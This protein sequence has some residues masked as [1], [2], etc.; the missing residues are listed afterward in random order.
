MTTWRT[1]DHTEISFN[2]YGS[3]TQP[4]TLLLLP[5]LLGSQTSQW[6][7]FI[8]PLSA[9]FRVVTMDLRGHGRSQNNADVLDPQRMILDISEL[10]DF[11]KVNTVH[12]AGYDMGGY[13]GMMLALNQPRR[14]ATLLMHATKFYWTRETAGKM[15]T[16]LDPDKMAEKVPAYANQLVQEHGVRLW[17]TLVRQ[18][19]DLINYLV[20]QGLSERSASSVQCPV[21]VSVGDRDKMVSIIEAQRLSRQIHRGECLVLPGVSHPFGSIRLIPLLPMMQYFHNLENHQ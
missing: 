13:L 4:N 3:E 5:G 20:D 18:S 17:R 12:I 1:S 11:L 7:E 9:N 8:R 10:L 2:I 21:L 15:K 19:S 16:Q 6:R 14:V